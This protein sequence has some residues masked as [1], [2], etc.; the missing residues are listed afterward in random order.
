MRKILVAIILLLSC[1]RVAQ[2]EKVSREQAEE[3]A[4]ASF[5][6]KLFSVDA[7]DTSRAV[8]CYRIPAITTAPDGSLI[9]A[10]DERVPSCGDLKWSR[11]INIVVRRST[12]GGRTWGR[13]ERVADFPDGQVGLGSIADFRHCQRHSVPFLQF[14]GP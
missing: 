12:D 10:I 9:A 6:Q 3:T 13:V 11:D 14:H 7:Q 4:A 1:M 5:R 8:S 2:A